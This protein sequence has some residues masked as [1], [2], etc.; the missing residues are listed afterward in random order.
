MP[1]GPCGGKV[2]AMLTRRS[3]TCLP[4]AAALALPAAAPAAIHQ[5]RYRAQFDGTVHTVWNFPKTQMQQDCYKTQ[6]YDGHGEETWHVHSTGTNKVLL[7]GNGV[8]TQFLFG[9]WSPSG[10]AGGDAS[11]LR[12]KGEVTRTR[13]DNDTFGPGTCGVTQPY[14]IDPP[15]TDCGTRLVN[16]EV[17]LAPEGSSAVKITPDVLADGNGVREKIGF[18]NCKLVTPS[19]VLEGSWPAATGRLIAGGRPVRGWF[20]LHRTLTA[21]GKDRW[22]GKQAVGGG[23]RTATTTIDWKLT[24]TRVGRAR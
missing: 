11:G 5:A 21:V 1:H 9:T 2:M 20:G 14:P 13:T 7:V 19:S 24:F 22:D 23:D 6:F 17:Q 15:K 16:Y 18:D 12:A 8:A 3:L 4:L 10:S